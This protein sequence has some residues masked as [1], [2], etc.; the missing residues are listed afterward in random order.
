MKYVIEH[1]GPALVAA[2]I[3]IALAALVVSMITAD[4]A[5]GQQ[6]QQAMDNFFTGMNSIPGMP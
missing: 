1:Y 2:A 3:M 4:G 6:F 5:V